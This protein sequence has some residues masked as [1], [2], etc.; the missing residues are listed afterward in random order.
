[1]G[2]EKF[3]NHILRQPLLYRA[4]IL[5]LFFSLVLFWPAHGRVGVGFAAVVQGI[6]VKFYH[7]MVLRIGVS[8]LC[9]TRCQSKHD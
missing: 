3:S 8:F 1:M 5:C 6:F 4:L 7:G 2:K 9:L